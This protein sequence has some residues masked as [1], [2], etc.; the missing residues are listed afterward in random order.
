MAN[1][2][3][4]LGARLKCDIITYDYSGYGVSEGK[5]SE[6]NIYAD[7]EAVYQSMKKRSNL[8]ASKIILYGQSIGKRIWL[9]F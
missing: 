3:I 5:A 4:V 6:K 9:R 7:I 1:F 8:D 2:L